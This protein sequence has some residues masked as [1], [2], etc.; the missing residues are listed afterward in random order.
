MTRVTKWNGTGDKG[1]NR[2]L[3]EQQID[4]FLTQC[5]AITTTSG[6]NSK[7]YVGLSVGEAKY[8]GKVCLKVIAGYGATTAQAT[9][10]KPTFHVQVDNMTTCPPSLNTWLLPDK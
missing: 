3:S 2:N 6:N 10:H 4:D 8:N 7:Y 9:T 1:T 5:S